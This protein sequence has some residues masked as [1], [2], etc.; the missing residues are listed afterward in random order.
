[1]YV[2]ISAVTSIYVR[3]SFHPLLYARTTFTYFHQL[4]F[5]SNKLLYLHSPLIFTGDSVYVG[6]KLPFTLTRRVLTVRRSLTVYDSRSRPP[7][8][9]AEGKLYFCTLWVGPGCPVWSHPGGIRRTK[10]GPA[11]IFCF[12]G[13]C[14]HKLDYL[15]SWRTT[16]PS[17]LICTL[18]VKILPC[19][20]TSTSIRLPFNF[21]KFRLT[22]TTSALLNSIKDH[23]S[24]M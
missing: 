16:V 15:Q 22:S 9:P 5:A 13:E 17:T 10:Q 7:A 11:L 19:R 1:M 21:R 20:S 4:P 23:A 2:H 12:Y 14:C 3:R 18:M 8:A 6:N 24:S